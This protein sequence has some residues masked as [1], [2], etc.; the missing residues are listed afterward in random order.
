MFFQ[1]QRYISYC[2]KKIYRPVPLWSGAVFLCEISHEISHA[3]LFH[4]YLCIVYY[5]YTQVRILPPQP[6]ID[7][8]R[9]VDFLSIAKVMVYYRR[10]RI[11]SR[12][13]FSQQPYSL[14]YDDNY[15]GVLRTHRSK[16]QRGLDLCY[17]SQKNSLNLFR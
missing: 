1:V 2:T 5:F 10:R 16:I 9:P 6:E 8:F 15:V 4:L 3:Y 7:R 12:E 11:S 14:G 13:A 17:L